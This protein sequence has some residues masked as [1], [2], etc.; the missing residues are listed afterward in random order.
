MRT[1]RIPLL[2]RAVRWAAVALVA[3]FIFYTS[4]VTTPPPEAVVPKLGPPD[5]IPLDKWRHFLAYGALAGSLWYAT[6]D[7]DRSVRL[8]ALFVLGVTIVYGIGIEFWQ[9]LIPRRYF[10]VGDAYA[11]ALGTLF[12]VPLFVLRE[13]VDGFG[14]FGDEA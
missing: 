13:R 1:V 14:L 9:S 5:L 8:V 2:P 3:G 4:I 12:V 7:W 6:L 11:N 10:S